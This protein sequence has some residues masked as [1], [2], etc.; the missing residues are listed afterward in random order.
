M[1][2]IV[3]MVIGAVIGAM[4]SEIYH[5][6]TE[7]DNENERK[8]RQLN[9]TIYEQRSKINDLEMEIRRIKTDIEAQK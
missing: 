9:D 1:E 8:E 5:R 6:F 7:I 3:F 4:I 2:T